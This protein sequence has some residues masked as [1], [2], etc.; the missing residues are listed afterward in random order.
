MKI[1]G[2]FS[3]LQENKNI[4]VSHLYDEGLDALKALNLSKARGIFS[5]V[6]SSGH[7]GY[8]LLAHMQLRLLT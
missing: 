4:M 7:E 8:A 2:A 6:A 5:S 3:L 1:L